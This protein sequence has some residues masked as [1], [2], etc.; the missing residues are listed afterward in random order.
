MTWCTPLPDAVVR[1][2]VD[3][4]ASSRDPLRGS[5]SSYRAIDVT[6]AQNEQRKKRKLTLPV[7]AIGGGKGLG[8]GVASTMRLAAENVESKI[9]PDSGHWVAEEAPEQLLA[10]LTPFLAPYRDATAQ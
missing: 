4:L 10:V 6:I 7:L 1:Y 5:F 3:G 2:Y 8:E 9:I